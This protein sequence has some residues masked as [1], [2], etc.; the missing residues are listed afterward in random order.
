MS[1]TPPKRRVPT[2]PPP[3]LGSV[4]VPVAVDSQRTAPVRRKKRRAWVLPVVIA[5]PIL[6]LAAAWLIDAK[7]LS[8]PQSP[9][10][11]TAPLVAIATLDASTATLPSTVA[12]VDAADQDTEIDLEPGSSPATAHPPTPHAPTTHTPATPIR[13]T[14]K[15]PDDAATAPI[16]PTA[17][18]AVPATPPAAPPGIDLCDETNCVVTNY[19]EACCEHFKPKGPKFVPH[20]GDDSPRAAELDLS[21]IRDGVATAKTAIFGCADQHPGIHGKVRVAVVV[22]PAGAVTSANVLESPDAALGTCVA[23]ALRHAHFAAT[24]KGGNFKYPIAF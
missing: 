6:G 11:T 3:D 16:P 21:L 17:P 12:S 19:A 23:D 15:P 18:D 5:A 10:P 14:T 24:T 22:A 9:A 1:A 20:T 2:P 8:G 7:L 4:P 13:P